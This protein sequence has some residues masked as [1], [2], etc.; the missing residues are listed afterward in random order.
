MNKTSLEASGDQWHM[1]HKLPG[2]GLLKY[3]LSDECLDFLPQ[4]FGLHTKFE[5]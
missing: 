4:P 2:I 5:I 1:L 3:D